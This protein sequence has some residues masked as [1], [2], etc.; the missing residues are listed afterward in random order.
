MLLACTQ[1][2]VL[3]TMLKFLSLSVYP[4]GWTPMQEA[5]SRHY[6]PNGYKNPREKTIIFGNVC[7]ELS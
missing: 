4:F 1:E 6:F 3:L 5:V 2:I 7:W